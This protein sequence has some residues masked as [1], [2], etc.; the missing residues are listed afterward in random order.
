MSDCNISL[1]IKIENTDPSKKLNF[2]ILLD[3]TRIFYSDHII[4][5]V[6]FSYKLNDDAET[7]HI[8]EFVMTSK[9]SDCTQIDSQGNIVSDAMLSVKFIEFD[10]ID[11]FN[12][13]TEISVYKHNFNGTKPAVQE[14]FYGNIGC[15]GRVEFKFSTPFYL[16]L[17]ENM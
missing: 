7:N 15:N 11:I 5:P 2:E 13:F 14:K 17:L 9:T 8:L 1:R 12:T 16:W 10:E 3:N 4:D 6:D